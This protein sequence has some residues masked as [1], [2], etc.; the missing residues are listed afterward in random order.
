MWLLLY[1][2]GI[3]FYFALVKI[4]SLFSTKAKAFTE[5]R[6]NI[7]DRIREALVNDPQPRIWFHFASLGEFEQ[8]R[9]VM[10]QLRIRYPQHRFF[11]TFFSPSGYEAKHRDPLCDYVFYLPNDSRKNAAFLLD[12]VQPK[13]VFFVKYEFWLYYM[14]AIHERGIPFFLLSAVFRESQFFF[15]GVARHFF[16][17]Y[18]QKF[19]AVF[20]QN[21]ESLLLARQAGVSEVHLAGDTRFDRV[22]QTIAAAEALPPIAAFKGESRLLIA[23]S[24]WPAEEKWLARWWN[25]HHPP[26]LKLLIA[27]HDVSPAHIQQLKGL[28]PEA[29]LLSEERDVQQTNVLIIDS[30]GLLARAYRY[31]DIALIGGAFGKGLHNILE[32]AA[33]GVPVIFGPRH[34]KFWEAAALKKA[35]GAFEITAYNELEHV[36]KHMCAFDQEHAEASK[37]CSRFVQHHAGATRLI[38]D[39]VARLTSY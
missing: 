38:M 33:F 3:R 2:T 16:S 20:V 7:Q 26:N 28:F 36:L 29:Q 30:I 27:P 35:G 32:A 18:L 9:P 24:S 8:G 12:C 37:Q 15:H 21:E 4:A 25:Q 23:G 10:E 19:T 17:S 34:A 39:E 5:G 22:L 11:V 6:R 31:A 13:L 14:Q 1:Q